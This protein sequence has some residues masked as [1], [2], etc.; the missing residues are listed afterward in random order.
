MTFFTFVLPRGRIRLLLFASFLIRL[1]CL[2]KTLKR[3]RSARFAA[4]NALTLG[5]LG[6]RFADKDDQTECSCQCERT[7]STRHDT[8]FPGGAWRGNR[9]TGVPGSRNRS[10]RSEA[11][12]SVNDVA[13][14]SLPPADTTASPLSL[15]IGQYFTSAR[16][17]CAPQRRYIWTSCLLPAYV[18]RWTCFTAM[19]PHNPVATRIYTYGLA[20]WRRH[21][22]SALHG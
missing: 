15:E 22:H 12:P 14:F 20:Q 19:R 2:P 18:L 17:C 3:F 6:T 7:K 13:S 11:A 21:P 5:Y 16:H 1:L 8:S 4:E 10:Y 9:P